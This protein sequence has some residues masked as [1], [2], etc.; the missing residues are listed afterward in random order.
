MLP[1]LSPAGERAPFLDPSARGLVL[2]LTFEHGPE[3]LAFGVIEGLSHVVRDCLEAAGPLPAE[4]RLCG[5][6]AGSEL[7]C[8]LIA[9]VTGVPTLRATNAEVGAKGAYL[10]A[11]V[12]VGAEPGIDAA[13]ARLVTLRDRFEPRDDHRQLHA[14][15]FERFLD[16]R[17]VCAPAW[18]RLGGGTSLVSNV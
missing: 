12:A 9:D 15:R 18:R 3:D 6:G 14:E 11:L 2:G 10:A 8:Q 4:L 5:G 16:T 7:W 1:Y 13:A 17:E